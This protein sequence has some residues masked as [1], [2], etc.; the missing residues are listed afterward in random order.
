[1]KPEIYYIIDAEDRLTRLGGGWEGFAEENG[2]RALTERRVTGRPLWDFISGSSATQVYRDV[3]AK[4][5]SGRLA[6]FTFRCDGPSCRRLMEMRIRA[7]SGGEVEFRTRTLSEK[8][9][10]LEPL[11][12]GDRERSDEVLHVCSWCNRIQVEAEVWEEV[13]VAVA[14]LGVMECDRMPM[15]SHGICRHCSEKVF[16]CV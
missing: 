15:L 8:A 12:D 13:E 9:R 11:L 3:V 10:R 2:G 16:A 14:R 1:M 4:V 5:R 7:L 6:E